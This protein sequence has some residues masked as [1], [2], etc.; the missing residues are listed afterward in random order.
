VKSPLVITLRCEGERWRYCEELRRTYFPPGRNIVPAHVALFHH[1]PG[2]ELAQVEADTREAC[3]TVSRFP[4]AAVR[5]R[6]LGGGV[7][8]NLESPQLAELHGKLSR[9]WQNWLTPQDRARLSP[10][11]TIQ[12]KVKPAAAKAL[13]HLLELTFQP[14]SFTAIGVEI[15]HYRNGPWQPATFV[16]LTSCL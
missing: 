11:V 16:P 7:A 15:W 12:N 6:S 5:V 3:A 1:L 13:L 9:A 2:E 4:V 14:F 10:H 8:L